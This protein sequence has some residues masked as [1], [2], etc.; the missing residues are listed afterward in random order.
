MK[1]CPFNK[2]RRQSGFPTFISRQRQDAYVLPKRRQSHQGDKLCDVGTVPLVAR[3]PVFLARGSDADGEPH[4]N[5][6]RNVH[7]C[8]FPD[9][10]VWERERGE[11]CMM[12]NKGDDNDDDVK[13][14]SVRNSVALS[15][16]F[17]VQS[18]KHLID[19]ASGKQ[20]LLKPTTIY[21][22]KSLSGFQVWKVLTK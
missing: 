22:C 6:P 17:T 12:V 20:G 19:S 11:K 15:P 9:E 13:V 3:W 1:L 14:R 2:A 4:W 10:T 5:K 16:V 21:Y 18:A 7:C 8:R